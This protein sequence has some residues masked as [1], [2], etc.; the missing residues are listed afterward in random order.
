MGEDMHIKIRRG[1]GEGI[2]QAIKR[3]IKD[4]FEKYKDIWSV[5]EDKF[6]N[7]K[8]ETWTEIFGMFH[9]E[10]GDDVSTFEQ[11]GETS[12]IK[13]KWET[14]NMNVPTYGDEELVIKDSTWKAILRFLGLETNNPS[15]DDTDDETTSVT[16]S[17]TG[18]V[19]V[20]TT[21]TLPADGTESVTVTATETMPV[22][23]TESIQVTGTETLP[24]AGTKAVQT[25]IDPNYPAD[26]PTPPAATKPVKASD[27]KQDKKPPKAIPA[28]VKE[29][30]AAMS[31]EELAKLNEVDSAKAGQTVD[32]GNGKVYVYD[33]QGRIIDEKTNGAYTRHITRDADG[34]IV[35][36]LD[37]ENDA[38]GNPIHTIGRDAQGAVTIEQYFEYDKKGNSTLG[39]TLDRNHEVCDYHE[40]EYD[41][42]GRV[43]KEIERDKDGNVTKYTKFKYDRH[44]NILK[45]TEY[46]A[47]GRVTC[48]EENKYKNGNKVSSTLVYADEDGVSGTSEWIY[49]LS[50]NSV[51]PS[52]TIAR[53][54]DGKVNYYVD[55]EYDGNGKKSK[56]VYRDSTGK[57][58]FYY[59]YTMA[60][61]KKIS[62]KRDPS[63]KEIERKEV[64]R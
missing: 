18:S 45:K 47:D 62:I 13:N 57:V 35:Q 58:K 54:A 49:S 2:S 33:A 7:Q 53:S 12:G 10:T 34:K 23:A 31:A 26:D 17:S 51:K 29:I 64:L 25:T 8:T 21:G 60:N 52:R 44:G 48:Q 19:Q 3:A 6:E 37:L 38:K 24:P 46:D 22:D 56:E 41:R 63:G 5:A 59:E 4:K 40:Y 11:K 42:K 32:I 16:S 50:G 28:P 36:I 43:T 15:T 9:K 14:L 1:S 55:F 30:T 39:L 61:G 27:I 20:T